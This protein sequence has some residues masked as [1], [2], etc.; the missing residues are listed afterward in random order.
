MKKNFRRM[1]TVA[2]AAV[3]AVIPT[4]MF[5]G[6]ETN[7]PEVVIT[8]EF[9]GTK[10]EVEYILS[11]KGAPQTVRHFIEL[12]D[13]G[14]YND[15]VVHDYVS[16]GSF[17]YCGG[18]TWDET[19]DELEKNLVEIDYWS[20]V[21]AYEEQNDYEFTQSVWAYNTETEAYD[22]PQYT[23]YGEFSENGCNNNSKTYTHNGTLYPGTLVMYY[24]KNGNDSSRVAVT[25]SDDGSNNE[26][27]SRQEGNLYQY[28]C[29][30][31]LFYTWTGSGTRPDLDALYSVFGYTK[32]YD[33]MEELLD[34]I[35]DYEEDNYSGSDESFTETVTI[36]NVNQYETISSVREAKIPADYNV[37]VTPIYIRSVKVTKY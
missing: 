28:N 20:W 16:S 12:A 13:A 17:L 15:T 24:T 3:F 34:A 14:Y 18:Y 2:A 35:S 21:K 36:S 29:A 9:N 5:S 25:R 37:P 27:E 6:C 19:A 30:T 33:R 7:N 26:G 8:Y 1:L 10:Y 31:S 23:V 11:R 4:V 22:I 32:D